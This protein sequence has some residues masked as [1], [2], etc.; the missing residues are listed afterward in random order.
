MGKKQPNLLLFK[1]G[2]SGEEAS[3]YDESDF[4]GAT[5]ERCMEGA[6]Y[7]GMKRKPS[8]VRLGYKLRRM[9]E[10]IFKAVCL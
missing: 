9:N 2:K 6:M 1:G 8:I 3:R 7:Q 4:G 5:E 10:S